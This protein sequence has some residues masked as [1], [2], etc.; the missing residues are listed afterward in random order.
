MR[1]YFFLLLG[2]LGIVWAETNTSHYPFNKVEYFRLDN[3]ADIY[4]LAD[5]KSVNTTIA[6]KVKT[7][8][9]IED[10]KTYGLSHLVEHIVFRDKDI[11]HRDY[12]DYFKENGATYVNATHLHFWRPV[13]Q[14]SLKESDEPLYFRSADAEHLKEELDRWLDESS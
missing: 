13:V 5:K 9:A 4:L 12:L 14:L 10:E 2:L 3:G 7:G 6:M 1:L 8:Y 11:P